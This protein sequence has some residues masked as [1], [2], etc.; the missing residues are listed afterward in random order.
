[1]GVEDLVADLAGLRIE[2]ETF[3][4]GSK[5]AVLV[6]GHTLVVSPAMMHLIHGAVSD[7]EFLEVLRAIPVVPVPGN[8]MHLLRAL[9]ARRWNGFCPAPQR[10]I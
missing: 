9:E 10:F 8:V 3:L 1:M 5:R 7:S 4:Q 2:C 6:G